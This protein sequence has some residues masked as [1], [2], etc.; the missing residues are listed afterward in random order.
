M[1]ASLSK[2]VGILLHLKG[3]RGLIMGTKGVN[4]YGH[5]GVGYGHEGSQF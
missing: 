4:R 5:K 1:L 3:K 2:N